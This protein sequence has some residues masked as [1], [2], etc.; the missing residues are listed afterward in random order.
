[1][2]GYLTKRS[3]NIFKSMNP[4]WCQLRGADFSYAHSRSQGLS[5][6]LVDTVRVLSVRTWDAHPTGIAFRTSRQQDF[7]CTA[8]NHVEFGLWCDALAAAMD[9][10]GPAAG[11]LRR[12]VRKRERRLRKERLIAIL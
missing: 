10:Q 5:G 9:P 1:M 7:F 12:D 8:P 2:E 11:S 3:N 4:R 6:D